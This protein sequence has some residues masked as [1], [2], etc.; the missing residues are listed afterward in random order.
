VVLD[1]A[2]IVSDVEVHTVEVDARVE[3]VHLINHHVLS[4]IRVA[5]D[6]DGVR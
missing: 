2:G 6:D 1:V 5:L 4:R 3:R